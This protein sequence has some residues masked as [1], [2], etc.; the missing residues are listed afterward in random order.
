M[1]E[2]Q[3]VSKQLWSFRKWPRVVS[4]L[5]GEFK[6]AVRKVHKLWRGKGK[7]L[8]SCYSS[9]VI[10]DSRFDLMANA[11]LIS[12]MAAL[13]LPCSSLCPRDHNTRRFISP[14][15]PAP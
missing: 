13:N 9:L 12:A 5:W 2:V 11:I 7:A 4:T 3:T 15:P 10:A 8:A 6:H 1:E 14:H